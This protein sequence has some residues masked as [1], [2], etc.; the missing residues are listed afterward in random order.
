[1]YTFFGQ[2]I[3]KVFVNVILLYQEIKQRGK[4]PLRDKMAKIPKSDQS[5]K[6]Q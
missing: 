2:K 1:M 5:K 6:K 4:N 3:Y